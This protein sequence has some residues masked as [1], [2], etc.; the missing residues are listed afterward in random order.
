[1][2]NTIVKKNTAFPTHPPNDESSVGAC[3]MWVSPRL[4]RLWSIL[5][6]L[7]NLLKTQDTEKIKTWRFSDDV[8]WTPEQR[9][10]EEEKEMMNE[11]EV[12]VAAGVVTL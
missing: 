11:G 5:S 8:L 12:V 10:G 4:A 7:V 3:A 6:S 1:M 9:S 2:N